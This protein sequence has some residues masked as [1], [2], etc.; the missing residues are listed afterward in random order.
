MA[1]VQRCNPPYLIK[2]YTWS[3]RKATWTILL[4][5]VQT[6]KEIRCTF[7]LSFKAVW[8]RNEKY[9]FQF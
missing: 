3:F 4:V 8:K 7:P 9:I 1:M 2:T 6:L 5:F